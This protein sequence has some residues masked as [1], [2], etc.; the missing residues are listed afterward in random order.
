MTGLALLAWAK[1]SI[2]K[3]AKSE[4]MRRVDGLMNRLKPEGFL[5]FEGI[6]GFRFV[7]LVV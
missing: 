3:P 2:I 6:E 5:E 4:L 7:V 1:L